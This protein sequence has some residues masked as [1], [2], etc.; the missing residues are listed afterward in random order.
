MV[1]AALKPGKWQVYNIIFTAPKYTKDK[2]LVKSAYVT[3]FH[4][5]VLVQNN[6]EILGP[7]TSHD[8]K[9]DITEPKLP[10]MLQEHT[11]EVSYRNIWIREL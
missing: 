5:G 10:L 2:M 3:V 7:T 8:K 1:N 6:V 9:L 4:N 11:N